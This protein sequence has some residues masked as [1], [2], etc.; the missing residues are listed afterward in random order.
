MGGAVGGADGA[1]V[2][3]AAGVPD[4][5]GG[6]APP[7]GGGGGGPARS[8][9]AASSTRPSAALA[10]TEEVSEREVIREMLIEIVLGELAQT[11]EPTSVD[12]SIAASLRS[13]ACSGRRPPSEG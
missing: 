13:L 7:G 3:G 4:A 1:G 9:G 11:S 6:G 8:V 10:R 12:S 2:A 5:G